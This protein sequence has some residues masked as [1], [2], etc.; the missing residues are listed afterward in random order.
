MSGHFAAGL[1]APIICRPG[2]RMVSWRGARRAAD[3]AKVPL[4]TARRPTVRDGSASEPTVNVVAG[5]QLGGDL[6]ARDLLPSAVCMARLPVCLI[7]GI[8]CR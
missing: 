5:L 4:I 1:R 8:R 7:I 2:G 3:I 6:F